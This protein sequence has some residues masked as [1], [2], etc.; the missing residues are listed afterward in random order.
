METI[1]RM[2][3]RTKQ[4]YYRH[5]IILQERQELLTKII[6][7]VKLIRASQA[8]IG[9]RKLQ[10]MLAQKGVKVGRDNLFDILR[11][12]GLLSTVYRKKCNT[13]TGKRSKY[14]NLLKTF[15]ASQRVGEILASDI[16]YLKIKSGFVYLSLTSDMYSDY[17]LGFSLQKNL[18]AQGPV[19]A[20]KQAMGKLKKQNP[21]ITGIHHS[22]HGTQY[23]SNKL[24]NEVMKYGYLTSMTG[25][26]K[27]YDNAKAE[28][29]NG[30]LKHELNLNK[31]F[32]NYEEALLYVKD[33]IKIYNEQR[34][35]ITQNYRTPYEVINAA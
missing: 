33:A 24:Q 16:T 22:D 18:G 4:G 9:V 14:P 3:G 8:Y 28:R 1:C 27:C 7:A 34:I 23:T 32:R 30:V 31:T 5:K 29:I 17:I 12:M 15:G 6:P 10:Y 19:L 25:V 2:F 20:L 21:N 11:E 26:G 13:S 35:I